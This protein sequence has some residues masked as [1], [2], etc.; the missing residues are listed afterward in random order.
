MSR[1]HFSTP[2]LAEFATMDGLRKRTGCEPRLWPYIILKELSDNALDAAEDAGSPP[3]ITVTIEDCTIIVADEGPGIEPDIVARI[4]D[5]DKQTSSRAV[6]VLPSRGAQ[7]NAMQSILAMGYVLAGRGVTIIES[8]G[9]RHEI[10][11]EADPVRGVPLVATSVSPCEATKGTRVAVRWPICLDDQRDDLETFA[12]RIVWFNPHLKLVIGDQENDA[13]DPK[14]RKKWPARRLTPHWYDDARFRRLLE[15]QAS[16]ALDH[17]RPC[18]A[19]GVTVREFDGLSSTAKA[20]AITDRLGLPRVALDELLRNHADGPAR[21]L[22]AMK[23][24]S[25]KPQP[26]RVGYLGRDHLAACMEWWGA[27]ERFEY[28]R[29]AVEVDSLPYVIEAAFGYVGGP[30]SLSVVTGLNFSPTPPGLD[31]FRPA[32]GQRLGQLWFQREDPT[33][34]AIHIVSPRFGFTDF[35]KTTV[36]LP[37]PARAKLDELVEA[38][39][40]KWTKQKRS[41]A[42]EMQA[43]ARREDKFRRRERPMNLVEAVRLVEDGESEDVMTRAFRDAEGKPGLPTQP[44]QIFYRARPHLLRLTGRDDVDGEDFGQRL[45]V[46]YMNEFPEKTARWS[47]TWKERGAVHEPHTGAQVGLGTLEV[48]GYVGAFSAPRVRSAGVTAPAVVTS[49][50]D[51]RYDGVLAIEKDGFTPLLKAARIAEKHDIAVVSDEGMSTTSC[52]ELIDEVCGR[53]GRP[54]FTLHDFDISG[55]SIQHMLYNTNARYRFRHRIATVVDFGLR[56]ADVERFSLPSE[57]VRLIDSGLSGEETARRLSAMEARLRSRGA[58]AEEVRFLMTDEDGARGVW[59]KRV[60]IN[61]FS[62][63]QLVAFLEEKLAAHGR[64]KIVPDEKTLADAYAA[65]V[66]GRRAEKAFREEI[67]VLNAAAVEVPADLIGRVRAALVED[68]ALSWD[69]ALQEI[70]AELVGGDG[71]A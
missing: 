30:A 54:L 64:G 44:R 39:A 70:V 42:R 38:V 51:C 9:V 11:F 63:A 6:H 55:F 57:R 59:G 50:P 3:A 23:G 16:D 27:D 62:S 48:R 29:A 25:P 5:Y 61:A 65:F 56:L 45:L 8:K 41:E 2:R 49:G 40:A 4:C 68:P 24:M 19:V 31:P 22:A 14:W 21:L 43:A 1:R 10:V 69:A 58:T 47:I 52:R 26:D 67:K 53:L 20:R 32:L 17:G 12:R 18:P 71:E 15:A 46:D 13:T 34:V 37:Y 35:G 33:V 66:R 28:R 36:A 60:E 7:G